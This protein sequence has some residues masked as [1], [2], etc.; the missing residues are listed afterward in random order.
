MSKPYGRLPGCASCSAELSPKPPSKML[1]RSST[2]QNLQSKNAERALSQATLLAP[3]DALVATRLVPNYSTVAGGAATIGFYDM[4]DLR[5]EI[6]VPEA[7]FE[8][9]GQDPNVEFF[10]QFPSSKE[11]YEFE[12]RGNPR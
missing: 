11:T 8:R 4:S 9:A 3:F 6:D 7:L 1:K 5:I 10:V 2:S 12:L